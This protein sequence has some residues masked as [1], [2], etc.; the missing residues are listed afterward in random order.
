MGGGVGLWLGYLLF[1]GRLPAKSSSVPSHM[2]PASTQPL[3]W[4]PKTGGCLKKV[5]PWH[6]R[7][8]R[9]PSCPFGSAAMFWLSSLFRSYVSTSVGSS[10]RIRVRRRLHKS[11]RLGPQI[12]FVCKKSTRFDS[13]PFRCTSFGLAIASAQIQGSHA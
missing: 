6:H 7:K 4:T 5:S 3:F 12:F 11:T 9:F 2:D 10:G 1:E 13:F 8:V